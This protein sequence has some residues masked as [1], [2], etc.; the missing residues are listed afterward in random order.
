ME[1]PHS[2]ILQRMSRES[3]VQR[4][5]SVFAIAPRSDRN[6]TRVNGE[7][8]GGTERNDGDLIQL[9]HTTFRFR[10]IQGV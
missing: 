6:P 9:G 7:P 1:H 2:G 4:T 3:V 5:D 8:T 10:T